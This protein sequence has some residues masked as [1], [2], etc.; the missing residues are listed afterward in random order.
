MTQSPPAAVRLLA[1]AALVSLLAALP[2]RATAGAGSVS[3]GSPP[4]VAAATCSAKILRK[5]QLV[6]IRRTTYRYA[7]RKVK[8]TKS[9]R[10]VVKRVTRAV[11]VSC[12]R[13]C[14]VMRSRRGKKQPVYTIKTVKVKSK[15]GNRIVTVKRKRKV[16]RFGACASSNGTQ[17]GTPVTITVLPGSSARLD[18]GA[19]QRQAN[20]SGTLK[21]FTTGP[22]K[23]GQDIQVNL[24]KG[25]LSLAQTPVFVD[26]DC[27]GQVSAA[28]RTG[29]PAQILLDATRQSTSTV[30]GNTVTAITYTKV[31][32][33]LELRNDDTGCTKP[34]ITTG[35][36]EFPQTFFLRGTLGAT[37]GLSNLTLTSAPQSLD[38]QACLSPGAPTQPCSG[39][40]IPL[41]ILVSTRLLV[42]ISLKP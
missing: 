28:I 12:A 26:D 40:V 3:A 22:I 6:T 33:P 20:L 11:R 15:R 32:L 35:Y 4:A 29:S 25:G 13:P 17:L 16:Y 7:Y 5:G 23:L 21:G 39:F 18:F 19:F 14:V 30:S 10:R 31:R 37:T 41:P 42:S 38:V 9:F 27:N 2:A 36:T 1:A 8:G 24:T 34:Y